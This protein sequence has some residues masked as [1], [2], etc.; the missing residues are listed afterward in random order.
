MFT[1]KKSCALMLVMLQAGNCWP[2][3]KIQIKGLGRKSHSLGTLVLC[4][5]RFQWKNRMGDGNY[6]SK[7]RVSTAELLQKKRFLKENKAYFCFWK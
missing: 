5:G 4:A 7:G 3:R 6:R 2:S 1:V